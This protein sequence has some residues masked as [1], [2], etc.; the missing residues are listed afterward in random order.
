MVYMRGLTRVLRTPDGR[1]STFP[2]VARAELSR[3]PR[4]SQHHR[5]TDSGVSWQESFPRS[6]RVKRFNFDLVYSHSNIASD[7]DDRMMKERCLLLASALKTPVTI[8]ASQQRVREVADG[9]SPHCYDTLKLTFRGAIDAIKQ[10]HIS[11]GSDAGVPSDAEFRKT[12]VRKGCGNVSIQDMGGGNV[13]PNCGRGRSYV[14]KKMMFHQP[15][16]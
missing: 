9:T 12:R 13:C 1:P 7:S 5:E 2:S 6:R 16:E 3:R 8:A 14:Q 11:E 15:N 10:G 4:C